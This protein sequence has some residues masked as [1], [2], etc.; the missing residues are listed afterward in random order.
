MNQLKGKQLK[1]ASVALDKLKNGETTLTEGR[2]QFGPNFELF[3]DSNSILQQNSVVNKEYVDSI[4]QGLDIKES[5]KIMI[6]DSG[7]TLSGEQTLQSVNLV[8]GDRVLVNAFDVISGQSDKNN[9]YIVKFGAWTVASDATI[10]DNL[11]SGAFT[12]VE[13][14]DF[15]D[16]G[17]VLTTTDL[18]LQNPNPELLWSKFTGA[19]LIDTSVTSGTYGDS[20]TNTVPT[21]TVDSKGRLTDAGEYNLD[22]TIGDAEDGDYTDGI[23]KDFNNNTPVGTA[24][25][26]F[27]EMLL[28]L[29]P[30]PPKNWDNA[31]DDI[32]FT[33]SAKS[34]RQLNSGNSINNL[35]INN[36]PTLSSNIGIGNEDNARVS[37]GTFEIVDNGTTIETVTLSGDSTVI[38]NTGN[39]RHGASVDP[40]DGI[41]G[42]AGFWKGITDFNI[43][44]N[45]PTI[46]A[47]SNARTIFLNH[48]G[49]DS[50]ETFNYYIDDPLTVSISNI[51][52]DIPVM[53]N[54]IS[55][56][57]SLT[58]SDTISNISFE[59][60]NVAS[61]F[62][63]NSFVWEIQQGLVSE[64]IGDPDTIP[65]TNG[66]TGTATNKS[67][68]IRNNQFSD[69][70]FS[71]SFRGKNSIGLFSPSNQFTSNLHRVD[72]VSNESNRLTSGSGTYPA[73][74]YGNTYLSNQSLLTGS[75]VNELMLNGGEYQYP[76]GDYTA[77]G[78]D[79]YS[80]ATGTRYATFNIGSFNN[81]SAFTLEFNGVSNFNSSFGASDLLIEVIIDGSSSWVDGQSPYSG[82]GN[83]GDGA[84]GVAAAS[85][86]TNTTRRI[87]FGTIARTG[88]IIVR[89]G[90]TLGSNKKFQS[91]SATN[92]V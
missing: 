82:V 10:P 65:T 55:G 40:Y 5:V 20:A 42:K 69:N 70:S 18:D 86:S 77:F 41:A 16:S 48:P 34:A 45:I 32:F 49:I 63:S 2:M 58:T 62:Y 44:G 67:T 12:F 71:M 21:F 39:I 46:S 92:I 31:F 36:T 22:I 14:G 25:D 84:N 60:N 59:I 68:N 64:T 9:I 85:S 23:F 1:D 51:T 43:T 19:G 66:E 35:Y 52:A 37:T 80:T 57:P 76:S 6:D 28:L 27:N 53:N 61:Y 78:G 91:I 87:T 11:T 74:G 3:V 33:E 75:Y 26:R 15:S 30:S 56:L 54:F 17:Y 7:I 89:I 72:S 29:A 13:E 24:V 81:N 38:K 79:N 90:L 83:P 50:P 73:T 88:N 8:S 4:A 47:S